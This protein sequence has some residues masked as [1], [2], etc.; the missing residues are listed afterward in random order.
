MSFDKGESDPHIEGGTGLGLAIVKTFTEAHGGTVTVESQQGDGSTFRISAAHQGER[1]RPNRTLQLKSEPLAQRFLTVYGVARNP[2]TYA[3][4]NC[5]PA[6]SDRSA[7]ARSRP[8]TPWRRP[9][10]ERRRRQKPPA[11]LL[12]TST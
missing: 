8:G 12:R 3:A 5:A 7:H 1:R 11:P 9:R 2:F 10:P 4:I 6:T